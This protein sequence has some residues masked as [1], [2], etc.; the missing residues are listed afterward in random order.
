M[1]SLSLL[2]GSPKFTSRNSPSLLVEWII[3]DSFLITSIIL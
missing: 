2:L 1:D 3:F